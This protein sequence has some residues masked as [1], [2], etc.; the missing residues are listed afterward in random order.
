MSVLPCRSDGILLGCVG[1][2]GDVLTVTKRVKSQM[3][4]S[5]D[6]ALLNVVIVC[7]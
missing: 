7:V 1:F 3:K 4:V 5:A 6:L 2:H